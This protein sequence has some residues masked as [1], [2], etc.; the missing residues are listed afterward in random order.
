MIAA[1]HF[2]AEPHGALH[3]GIEFVASDVSFSSGFHIFITSI[4]REYCPIA[5]DLQALQPF[6]HLGFARTDFVAIDGEA[7]G[8]GGLRE[9]FFHVADA[10]GQAAAFVG[11]EGDDGLENYGKFLACGY[12]N[13]VGWCCKII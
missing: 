13:I 8:D 3:V 6:L 11:G 4:P 2:G 10:V 1:V 5:L 7:F 12:I 9:G